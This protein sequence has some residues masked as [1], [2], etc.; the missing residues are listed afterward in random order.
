LEKKRPSDSSQFHNKSTNKDFLQSIRDYAASSLRDDTQQLAINLELE[1]RY[2]NQQAILWGHE[3]GV[4]LDGN[5]ISGLNILP[6]SQSS[7]TKGT[8]IASNGS[9]VGALHEV[10]ITNID[11]M[12][13]GDENE[14]VIVVYRGHFYDEALEEFVHMLAPV[15]STSIEF[16]ND[17]S[18]EWQKEVQK[19]FNDCDD[20]LTTT[21]AKEVWRLVKQ[22]IRAGG[23]YNFVR[24]HNKIH[25]LSPNKLGDLQYYLESHVCEQLFGF[26]KVMTLT[27]RYIE[28][29]S[30][31]DIGKWEVHETSTGEQPFEVFGRIAGVVFDTMR[32]RHGE[33]KY[34]PHVHVD[35]CMKDDE[36]IQQ[37][38]GLVR[39]PLVSIIEMEW[40]E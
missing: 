39:I 32:T 23:E 29:Q 10:E 25:D 2:K 5:D 8:Y 33:K 28:E 27:S 18:D 9:E 24:L 22:M 17:M 31:P 35:E 37:V 21:Q 11:V 14:D 40:E 19:A 30:N 6:A 13:I 38:E 4:I 1:K 15:R 20:V 26:G 36:D 12:A 3:V 34:L 16:Y 7:F